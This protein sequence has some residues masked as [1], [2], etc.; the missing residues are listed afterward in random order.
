M[1][2]AEHSALS[3]ALEATHSAWEKEQAELATS[4]QA[5]ECLKD[6]KGLFADEFADFLA[7]EVVQQAVAAR[8][9]AQRRI[10][11]LQ[12]HV[13]ATVAELRVGASERVKQ[14]LDDVASDATTGAS[15]CC[16]PGACLG[17]YD[18]NAGVRVVPTGIHAAMA[19]VQQKQDA[20]A[21]LR[22]DL[23]R[24]L[25]S[26]TQQLEAVGVA[27]CAVVVWVFVC[28]LPHVSL[29]LCFWAVWRLSSESGGRTTPHTSP[30][31]L[32]GGCAQRC[33]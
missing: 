20:A 24:Q 5:L 33:C 31:G 30:P 4:I 10:G 3:Q 29:V 19:M 9:H 21:A 11:E 2:S 14:L 18:A 28:A 27:T 1:L 12:G 6:A 16:C 15:G 13:E 17:C 23:E 25:Q 26:V 22:V 8:S 7:T 32:R